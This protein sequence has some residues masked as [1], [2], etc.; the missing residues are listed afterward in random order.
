MSCSF[1]RGTNVYASPSTACLGF[2][3][4]EAEYRRLVQRQLSERDEVDREALNR[5]YLFSTIRW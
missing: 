2:D 1:A 5:F 4:L 3:G